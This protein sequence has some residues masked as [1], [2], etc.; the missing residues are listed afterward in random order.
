MKSK[1]HAAIRARRLAQELS[2]AEIARRS[3]LQ[4]RQVSLV[5]RGGDVMLST[6]LKLGQA[7]DLELLAVP[8]EDTSR[9][10]S[11][12]NA[13]HEPGATAPASSLLERYRVKDDEEKSDG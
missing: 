5:E 4:Q 9:V 6:L 2:Q 8:R 3:G 12:L 10:E 13:R 11:L 1:I 7:L